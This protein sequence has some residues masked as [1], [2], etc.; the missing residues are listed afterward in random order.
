MT[1]FS[2]LLLTYPVYLLTHGLLV[3]YIKLMGNQGQ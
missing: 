2:W 1:P 3:D